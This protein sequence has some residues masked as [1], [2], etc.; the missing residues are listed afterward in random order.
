MPSLQDIHPYFGL[1]EKIRWYSNGGPCWEQLS[2][3]IEQFVGPGVHA[4][5]VTN[6][7]LGIMAL[8]DQ[9]AHRP[10]LRTTTGLIGRAPNPAGASLVITPS[11]T[12]AAAASAIIWS[13]LTPLL[14]DVDPVT[15]QLAP[16]A[17]A[18]ALDTHRGQVAAVLATA[19]FGCPPPPEV[20]NAWQYAC[21]RH[22]VP[23]VI[24]AAAGFGARDSSGA[25]IGGRGTAEVFSFH[26]TKPFAVGEGGVITTTDEELAARLVQLINFGFDQQRQVAM[27]GGFNAKM[28]EL[29]AAVGLA[30]MDGYP[31]VL[32][33]RRAA[34]KIIVD[35]IRPLGYRFQ[36]GC[37]GSTWQ[38]VPA[39][40]PEGVERDRL[41]SDLLS[42]GVEAR[43][44]FDV[45][46]HAHQAY[47]D[48]PRCGS[49][50]ITEHLAAGALSLPMANDLSAREIERV[51]HAVQAATPR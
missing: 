25:L 50:S 18:L 36:P 46:L 9:V 7:T 45:P 6:G 21:D 16:E 51:V 32:S 19:S 2:R 48:L 47:A 30:V 3:R 11:Y 40:V 28:D 49:L 24:D 31:L 41:M 4:V 14:V 23:L 44:Y 37:E 12:F 17:L 1:A 22:L 34:A 8:L 15:W 38:H 5:P 43:A 33:N 39:Q 35:A 29:H 26:A 42:A 27:P 10:P 13:G 20:T